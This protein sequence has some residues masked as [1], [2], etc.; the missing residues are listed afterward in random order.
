V[1]AKVIEHGYLSIGKR[2]LPF[3]VADR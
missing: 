1:V 3:D 2:R